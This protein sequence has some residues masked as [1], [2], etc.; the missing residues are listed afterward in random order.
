MLDVFREHRPQVVFHAAAHKHVPILEE[1]PQEALLTNV[2]GTANVVEAATDVRHGAVRPD[3]DRQGGAADERDGRVQADGRGHRPRSR[4]G[5]GTA[6]CAVRFGNVLGSRGS[7]VPTFLSQIAAGGPVTVTDPQMTR[8]FMS[9]EEAVQLVLAGRRAR[10]RRRGVHARD[11]RAGE[12]PGAGQQVDPAL[13]TRPR[14]RHRRAAD[15]RPSGREAPRGAGRRRRGARADRAPGHRG[16]DAAAA[17][18]PPR[19]AGGS[20]R[21]RRSPR[22][23]VDAELAEQLRGRRDRRRARVSP[24]VEEA[25]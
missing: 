18:T 21:W 1:H 5:T 11:G 16:G 2:L 23:G 12:H 6:L 9:V 17:R 20:A 8:Y 4:A 7:V 15:R 24:V 3:L 19:S 14:P 22:R 25:S 13:G 10:A